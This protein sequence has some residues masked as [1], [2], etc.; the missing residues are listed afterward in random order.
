MRISDNW[1]VF[2]SLLIVGYFCESF[3]YTQC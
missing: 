3:C 1:I 2:L